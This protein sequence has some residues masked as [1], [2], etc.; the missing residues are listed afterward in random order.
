M[1]EYDAA[2]ME[3]D[4][5]GKYRRKRGIQFWNDIYTD[6]VRKFL[7]CLLDVKKAKA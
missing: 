1:D 6:F 5:L 7:L 4:F 2:I 3:A